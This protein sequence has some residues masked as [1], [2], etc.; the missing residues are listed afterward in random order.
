MLD[1]II[2]T[3]TYSRN[4]SDQGY[5][6]CFVD[7]GN[8][9]ERV[10][11]RGNHSRLPDCYYCALCDLLLYNRTFQGCVIISDQIAPLEIVQQLQRQI[12]ADFEALNSEFPRDQRS[13]N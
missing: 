7:I 5:C 10:Y 13:D 11:N 8:V 3:Y 1:I 9:F 12:P 2:K 4:V 6:I